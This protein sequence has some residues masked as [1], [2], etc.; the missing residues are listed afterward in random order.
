MEHHF[1]QFDV[2]DRLKLFTRPRRYPVR[3]L[4][5]PPPS[6]AFIGPEFNSN[7][8]QDGIKDI[9]LMYAIKAA[10]IFLSARLSSRRDFQL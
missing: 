7:V 4:V 5:P 3:R 6:P 2:A 10:D 1:Q 9:A 8:L